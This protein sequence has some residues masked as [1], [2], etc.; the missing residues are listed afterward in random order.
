VRSIVDGS[1]DVEDRDAPD[2]RR[3]E[4]LGCAR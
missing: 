2:A 1:A 3:V 4:R